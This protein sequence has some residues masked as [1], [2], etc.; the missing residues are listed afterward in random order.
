MAVKVLTE[1]KRGGYAGRIVCVMRGRRLWS[2]ASGIVRAT[3]EDARRDAEG[4]RDQ[5]DAAGRAAL[6]KAGG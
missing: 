3:R 1:R 6:E 5:Q 4:L 2:E